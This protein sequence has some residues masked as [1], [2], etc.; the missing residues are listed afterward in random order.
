MTFTTFLYFPWY[1]QSSRINLITCYVS[2]GYLIYWLE[3]NDWAQCK[4][5]ACKLWLW[6][7]SHQ[8]TKPFCSPEKLNI[9]KWS[10]LCSFLLFSISLLLSH[11]FAVLKLNLRNSFHIF[12]HLLLKVNV[13]D[14]WFGLFDVRVTN[15]ACFTCF[16]FIFFFTS[17]KLWKF[18]LLKH[19]SQCRGTDTICIVGKHHETSG[20]SSL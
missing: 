20:A 8:G 11:T 1:T 9:L 15:Y 19:H 6:L 16:H 17:M 5:R 10:A 13:L 14:L 12:H 18:D 4:K 2:P 3:L 7:S